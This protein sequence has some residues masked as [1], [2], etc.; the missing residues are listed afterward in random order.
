MKNT[1]IHLVTYNEG[2]NTSNKSL[3]GRFGI[4]R[5]SRPTLHIAALRPDVGPG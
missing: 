2:Q 1:Q 5:W 4:A 3:W